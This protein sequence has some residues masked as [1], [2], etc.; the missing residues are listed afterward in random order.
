[1][2]KAL[3]TAATI[4]GSV[5]AVVASVAMFIPGGQPVAAVAALVAA[6]AG[7]VA[8]ATS[9]FMKPPSLGGG[10]STD[11]KAD[12]DAPLPYIVGRTATGGYIVQQDAYGDNRK[13]QFFVTAMSIGPVQEIEP[14]LVD[15]VST[16]FD[17]TG[18]AIGYYN[19]LLWR[20]TQLGALPESA[21]MLPFHTGPWPGW[22]STSK[23]SGLAAEILELKYDVKGDHNFRN[24][25]PKTLRVVK[26][27]K[28]YDPRLDSTYPGGSGSCRALNESTYVYSE[29]PWLHAL[30]YALG[31]FQNGKRV[32]GIGMAL[33]AI[34]VPAIVEA[35]NVA[36]ANTWKAGG[37]I[38]S[39]DNKWEALKSLAQAGGGV[40]I[41]M[42]AQLSCM[43][44][45]P[46]VSLATIKR[47]DLA[48]DASVVGTRARRERV[49]GIVPRYRSES[50]DWEVVSGAVVRNTAYVTVDGGERTKELEFP[51]VQQVNQAAQ[52]ARYEIENAREVGPITLQLKPVWIGYKPGDCLT[53]DIDELHLGGPKTCIVIARSLDPGTGIVTLTL[54]G[55][56]ASKH[57]AALGQT[58]TAPPTTTTTAPDLS[59]VAA[60]GAGTWAVAA[61]SITAGGVTQPALVITGASDND[62]ADAIVFEYRING[63]STW[64]PAGIDPPTTVRKEILGVSPGTAY[65]VAISYRVHGVIGQRLIITTGATATSP[66]A[67]TGSLGTISTPL[68]F[69]G[70]NAF[71]GA[72]SSNGYIYHSSTLGLVM[73]G[74]GST[75]DFLLASRTGPTVM[76]V[77]PNTQTAQFGGAVQFAGIG[78]TASAG[79]AFLDSANNNNLLRSTSSRDFKRNIRPISE[80][81]AASFLNVEPV[82]FQSKADADDPEAWFFGFTS[83]NMLEH[84]PELVH[85]GYRE[86]DYDRRFKL[87]RR[88]RKGRKM[89][90]AG[91]MYERAPAFHQVVL[92][93]HEA[94]IEDHEKRLAAVEA[95]LAGLRDNR[96][97][98]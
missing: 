44:N 90:P 80:E 71:P 70:N 58:T 84:R 53:V 25:V 96:S 4:V 3:H 54:V 27:V 57:S 88:L 77:L 48:G 23:L 32:F 81:E 13:Y 35:A 83:E 33:A 69:T 60:P 79:N 85:W 89:R 26:G 67:T 74:Q 95:A 1:V 17:G 51:L 46:R 41:Q 22:D 14:L 72:A 86:D 47:A 42:S 2:A 31:R 78:T 93:R 9:F 11:W 10:T 49:N 6:G 87:E 37:E 36:D 8:A 5:A 16:S 91:I 24:G 62:A 34:N 38:L 64:T 7:L 59:V 45:T 97:K 63:S 94:A 29:N 18:A 92:R 56:T 30:T 98:T 21:A 20:H 12:P 75:C 65:D 61:T 50:H 66:Y 28:V 68:Q 73:L 55:E 52:L 76:L 43:V 82:A 15:N 19:T 39:T 40:P